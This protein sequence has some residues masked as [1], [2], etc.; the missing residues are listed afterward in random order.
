MFLSGYVRT[1]RSVKKVDLAVRTPMPLGEK[2][3]G[4]A[5]AAAQSGLT[6]LQNAV[7]K[8]QVGRVRTDEA[9]ILPLV[10]VGDLHPV[11][12]QDLPAQF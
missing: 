4:A 10:E 1:L 9:F 7:V 8:D 12:H 5:E 3:R 11:G 2:R 6:S